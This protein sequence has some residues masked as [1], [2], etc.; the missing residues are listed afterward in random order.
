MI[1]GRPIHRYPRPRPKRNAASERRGGVFS[2][3]IWRAVGDGVRSC[4]SHR[5]FPPPRRP[6]DPPPLPPLCDEHVASRRR[7]HNARPTTDAVVGAAGA[8]RAL[9]GVRTPATPLLPREGRLLRSRPSGRD[10]REATA[11]TRALLRGVFV[12]LPHNPFSPRCHTP[13]SPSIGTYISHCLFVWF[14]FCEVRR[15]RASWACELLRDFE[16]EVVEWIDT[17]VGLEK[18]CAVLL[19]WTRE[20]APLVVVV[21]RG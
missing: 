1:F 20:G 17:G 8:A 5:R 18:P 11:A 7:H 15:R 6:R 14:L 9:C 16:A 10:Q 13:H 21:F 19:L 2:V 4:P 12:S 3:A